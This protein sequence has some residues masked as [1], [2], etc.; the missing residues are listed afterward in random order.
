VKRAAGS[1]S[2]L[3]VLG[4]VWRVARLFRGVV[5]GRAVRD[6][7]AVAG[8]EC[9]RGCRRSIASEEEAV[10]G[11]AA[12]ADDARAAFPCRGQR[13]ILAGADMWASEDL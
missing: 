4:G 2:G 6:G 10:H 1:G 12:A 13:S 3:G 9:D 8:E 5:G 7:R 11:G